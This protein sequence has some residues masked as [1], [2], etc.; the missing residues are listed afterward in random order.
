MRPP[1]SRQPALPPFAD[2]GLQARRAGDNVQEGSRKR[3]RIRYLRLLAG[4]GLKL[5]TKQ[6]T[7]KNTPPKTFA[8]LTESVVDFELANSCSAVKE[9]VDVGESPESFPGLVSSPGPKGISK[10]LDFIS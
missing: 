3:N 5:K 8:N 7:K 10:Y 9:G 6:T 2:P 1:G 4:I